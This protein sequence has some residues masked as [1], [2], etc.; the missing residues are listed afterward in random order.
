[1][2]S[3][4]GALPTPVVAGRR[5]VVGR[6]GLFVAGYFLLGLVNTLFWSVLGGTIDETH[7]RG[8]QLMVTVVA[9]AALAGAL[10][11]VAQ[12]WRATPVEPLGIMAAVGSIEYLALSIG[13]LGYELGLTGKP[14]F[15]LVVLTVLPVSLAILLWLP[16]PLL[17]VTVAI[18]TLLAVVAAPLGDGLE[19]SVAGKSLLLGVLFAAM[20]IIVDLR[21]RSRA[22]SVLHYA[23]V[24]ALVVAKVAI[25]NDLGAALGYAT[26]ST[27]ALAELAIA[28]LLRRRSWAYSGW[29]TLELSMAG[30]LATA[31]ATSPVS[32]DI[33]G[34]VAPLLLVG[35]IVMQRREDRWRRRLLAAMPPDLAER[36]PA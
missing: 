5:D 32:R 19:S 11:F 12:R 13:V 15:W 21:T 30:L 33:L 3:P 26:L 20:A 17:G 29:V 16:H 28:L 10:L 7:E 25:V 1:M 34:A 27:V 8:P 18:A 24:L 23:G 9:A 4:T 14:L 6:A 35:A 2:W 22:A 31:L 36:F